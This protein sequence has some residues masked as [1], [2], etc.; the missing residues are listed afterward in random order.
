MTRSSSSLTFISS[1]VTKLTQ[2]NQQQ[3]TIRKALKYTTR[4]PARATATMPNV[5]QNKDIVRME[6]G[7]RFNQIV[8]HNGIVYLAGQVARG[9]DGS[10]GGQTTAILE[11]IDG[12]L[13]KAGTNKSR[14]LSAMI[15]MTD[16]SHVK[17]LNAAWDAWLDKENMPVRAC[18]QSAL[19]ADDI[20]VEIQVTAAM[21]SKE[22]VIETEKAASAV[23]PYNQGI[24]VKDGTVYVSGC[25]GLLPGSGEMAGGSVEEQTKQALK[26]LKMIVEAAGAG[27]NGLL[28]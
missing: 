20:T 27:V 18:V 8:S 23:G 13:E 16:V 12:L 15:W 17:E 9:T 19:V 1:F 5:A 7:A 10:V 2:S 25:I 3:T 24:V 4:Q 11:K 28:L 14:I 22:A 26:N 6:P 21:P